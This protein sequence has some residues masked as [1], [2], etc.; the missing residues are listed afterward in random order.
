MHTYPHHTHIKRQH[1]HRRVEELVLWVLNVPTAEEEP[2][3]RQACELLLRWGTAQAHYSAEKRPGL[4]QE[5]TRW[6]L[7]HWVRLGTTRGSQ[8]T[9]QGKQGLT[10]KDNGDGQRH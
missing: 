6:V 2:V 8:W 3:A 7:G 4:G 10:F 9:M 1:L 5:Y